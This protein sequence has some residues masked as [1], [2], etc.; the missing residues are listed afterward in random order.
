[1]TAHVLLGK[2]SCCCEKHLGFTFAGKFRR[3][4]GSYQRD[5]AEGTRVAHTVKPNMKVLGRAWLFF[6][7]TAVVHSATHSLVELKA[8]DP[9]AAPCHTAVT[10]YCNISEEKDLK[11]G[12]L[13]WIHKETALCI[14]TKAG[15]VSLSPRVRCDYKPQAQL[16]LS[17]SHLWPMDQGEYI[18]SLSSNLGMKTVSTAVKVNECHGEVDIASSTSEVG[19]RFHGV[20]P[21]GEVH[22]FHQGKN[23][24]HDSV[25]AKASNANHKGMYSVSSTL[26][27]RSGSN[28][29]NCSLW[30]PSSG[31]YLTSALVQASKLDGRSGGKSSAVSVYT[32]GL[33]WLLVHTRTFLV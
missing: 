3:V 8:S 9:V 10:L 19:C 5:T 30:I 18:C 26:L 11:V 14:V 7:L 28:K 22:W 33:S 13:T 23:V 29:Y 16:A 32:A 20:Y 17:I 31:V 15:P 24:S 25:T 1:M 27:T 4:Q 12:E 2:K 6:W 21:Q